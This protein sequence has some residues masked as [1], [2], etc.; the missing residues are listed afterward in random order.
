M[1]QCALAA[2]IKQYETEK[3]A[4]WSYFIVNILCKNTHFTHKG[5][6][7][8]IKNAQ[9]IFKAQKSFA[10]SSVSQIDLKK[11]QAYSMVIHFCSDANKRL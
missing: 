7:E 3:L 9:D 10:K 8:T 4:L 11:L 6:S 2:F 1:Q 5:L